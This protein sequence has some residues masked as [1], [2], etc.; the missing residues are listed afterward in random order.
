[1]TAL[2][3]SLGAQD[4]L[5][6]WTSRA[7]NKTGRKPH[8]IW[9][10]SVVGPGAMSGWKVPEGYIESPTWSWGIE[11]AQVTCDIALSGLA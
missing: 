2:N 6:A 8:G 5:D 9:Y 7:G 3:P 4:R 10:H 1:M 11:N